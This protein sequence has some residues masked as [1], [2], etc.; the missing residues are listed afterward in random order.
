MRPGSRRDGAVVVRVPGAVELLR[1]QASAR[2]VGD[3]Q[4]AR[5][6][7]CSLDAAAFAADEPAVACATCPPDFAALSFY[8]L[9]GYPTGVGALVARRD[10][11]AMLRRRYFGGGTVQFVSVQ[12]RR[13]A[14]RPGAEAFEDGTPNFLAMPAVCDGL[15]WLRRLGMDAVD[16]HV[17][18]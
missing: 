9:F 11:L 12:N 6:I 4:R 13:R 10:A 2:W 1:R 8:K 3:A 16:R 14:A 5:A 7:A 15:R 17:S 18:R